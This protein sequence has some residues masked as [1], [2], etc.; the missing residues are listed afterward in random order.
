MKKE[1]EDFESKK[2]KIYHTLLQS[3]TGLVL[4]WCVLWFIPVEKF[5]DGMIG[6][7]SVFSKDVSVT[8]TLSI[9]VMFAF[10]AFSFGY[11]G[12]KYVLNLDTEESNVNE[13]E[14]KTTTSK[15]KK[16]TKKVTKKEE[17]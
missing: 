12:M 5:F 17:K 11:Y 1:T 8:A 4:V 10:I 7:L 9:I 13:K 16:T 14:T 6:F 3:I 2:T 15:P